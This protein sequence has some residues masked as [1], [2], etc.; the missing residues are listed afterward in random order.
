MA[1]KL[2]NQNSE[3]YSVKS[4][5]WFISASPDI[6][7]ITLPIGVPL[8]NLKPLI[9][10][11]GL[12]V[13]VGEDYLCSLTTLNEIKESNN[14]H[15]DIVENG[16]I[17]VKDKEVSIG[18]TIKI[19]E[20]DITR[21]QS[22][23]ELQ[24]TKGIKAGVSSVEYTYEGNKT[25]GI[26]N[27]LIKQIDYTLNQDIVRGVDTYTLYQLKLAPNEAYSLDAL[28]IVLQPQNELLDMPKLKVFVQGI[29][30]RLTLLRKDFNMIKKMFFDG[31]IPLNTGI[32]EITTNSLSDP[33]QQLMGA[34]D[35]HQ[36]IYKEVGSIQTIRDTQ[37]VQRNL[38]NQT[39]QTQNQLTSKTQQLTDALN[40]TQTISTKTQEQIQ[41]ELDLTKTQLTTLQKKVDG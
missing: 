7:P 13:K 8:Q 38:V 29:T 5:N 35:Y 23:G 21:L 20:L 17:K 36:V 26:S 25:D 12:I 40:A 15:Y 19:I 14:P 30:E 24:D 9:Q 18:K 34:K 32:V 41:R 27:N 16:N 31:E 2:I 22:I 6:K 39:L 4:D 10:A 37:E 11:N 28:K 33:L 3:R 1:N